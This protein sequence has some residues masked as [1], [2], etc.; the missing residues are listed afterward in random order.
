M[1]SRHWSSTPAADS[2]RLQ[3]SQ[4]G[5]CVL[6]VCGTLLTLP[7]ALTAAPAP[8]SP[9]AAAPG[10]QA[11]PD[12]KLVRGMSA[13]DVKKLMGEPG[14][15]EAME[16]PSGKAEIWT[17]T[18]E[19]EN[20]SAQVQVGSKPITISQIG[21]DNQMHTMTIAE[22][23]IFKMQHITVVEQVDILMFNGHFLEKK[24]TRGKRARYD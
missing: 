6:L 15:V 20:R 7:A 1:N 19:L 17:Y 2:R 13:A 22:E 24:V 8:A 11:G 12:A 14:K 4:L 18:R 23:P 10:A 21:A 16:A 3:R 5:A 9:A